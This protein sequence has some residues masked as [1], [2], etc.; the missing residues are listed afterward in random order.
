MHAFTRSLVAPSIALLVALVAPASVLAATASDPSGDVAACTGECSLYDQDLASLDASLSGSDLVVTVHQYGTG[1][2]GPFTSA[3]PLYWPIVELYTTNPAP[4]AGPTASWYA[5]EG[6]FAIESCVGPAGTGIG[7]FVPGPTAPC[8][9]GSVGTVTQATPDANTV[10]YT[11]A[12]SSLGS[13]ATIGVRAWQTSAT[14]AGA[15]DV[16]PDTGL[17][18]V[19]SAP[20]LT[21]AQTLPNLVGV[22]RKATLGAALA[23]TLHLAGPAASI[24]VDVLAPPTPAKRLATKL[25]LVGTTTLRDVAKGNVPFRVR[26]KKSWRTSLGTRAKVPVTVRVTL[27]VAG[28]APLVRTTRV[29][30]TRPKSTKPSGTSSPVTFG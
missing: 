22:P 23:G 13:P 12:L 8:A 25:R 15:V 6:N 11:V 19:A 16:V 1:G 24:K 2:K 28:Q 4:T 5:H 21:P 26:L 29:V 14:P 7:L 17:L 10:T 18:S 30:L 9:A 27:T 3:S 20:V